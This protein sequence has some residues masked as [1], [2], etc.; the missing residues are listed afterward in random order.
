MYLPKS[1]SRKTSF[2]VGVLKVMT[3]IEGSGS[4][5]GSISQR[6]GYPD[7]HQNV[8][9]PEHWLAGIHAI[10]AFASCCVTIFYFLDSD[11]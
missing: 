9:D 2:F 8:I 11:G 5:S 1:N 10:V 7:P 3:K 4:A 6:D